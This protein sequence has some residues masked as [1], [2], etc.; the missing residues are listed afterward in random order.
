MKTYRPPVVPD[1]H[2]YLARPGGSPELLTKTQLRRMQR[3]AQQARVQTAQ[4]EGLKRQKN[5]AAAD[6][7]P[8]API[9]PPAAK[10][11][12][13]KP[14]RAW[15]P[16]QDSDPHGMAAISVEPKVAALEGADEGIIDVYHERDPPFSANG[17]SF[18]MEFHK[19]HSA[20]DLYGMTPENRE[21]VEFA[22]RNAKAERL[23]ITNESDSAIKAVYQ[24]NRE[25][26]A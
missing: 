22:L 18:L 6:E 2:W 10:V 20:I 21:I 24:A 4:V 16:R 8:F 17:L 19:D 5:M 1:D 25:A 11:A 26:R 12:S 13:A 9:V 14:P 23:L 15:R 7:T 3:Q